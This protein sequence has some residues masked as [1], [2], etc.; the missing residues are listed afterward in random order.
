MSP[1]PP[2]QPDHDDAPSGLERLQKVLAAAGIG[3]RRE[4]E[5]LITGGRVEVDGEFVTELGRKVDPAVHK[6]QVDGVVLAKQKRVYFALN[7]PVGVVSTNSDPD[8]RTRVIDLIK[9]N[10]RL[11]PVGRLDR[12]SEGLILVTNDGELANRLTHPRYGV[13]KIYRVRVVGKPTA[14]ALAK[15]RKGV[16]LSE[17]VA[18]VSSIQVKRRYK[19][20]TELEIVLQEGLNREIRRILARVGHKVVQLKRV[21]I[22]PIRLGTMP[23][24]AHRMLSRDEV[25]ALRRATKR[26][27][28]KTDTPAPDSKG[29][30]ARRA[31]SETEHPP[32]A[33]EKNAASRPRARKTGSSAMSGYSRPGKSAS[34]GQRKKSSTSFSA[35]RRGGESGK[36]VDRTTQSGKKTAKKKVARKKVVRK[37]AARPAKPATSTK[38]PSRPAKKKSTRPAKGKGKPTGTTGKKKT[39]RKRR[40]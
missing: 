32:A 19:Q 21:S 35:G 11:Y 17:G 7:K 12:T 24:G 9:S 40:R 23:A 10:E 38:K 20:S 3:S 22:G 29:K 39:G 36:S 27:R 5:E 2:A 8:G 18:R 14:E 16:Y 4:C 15:V 37:K 13:E 1:R 6:I 25:Q 33:G 30:P 31:T 34:P 26:S 28:K